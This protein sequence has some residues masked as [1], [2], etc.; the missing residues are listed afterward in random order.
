MATN[1][2]FKQTDFTRTALDNDYEACEFVNCSFSEIR[3]GKIGFENC[4]FVQC[5]FS[6]CRMDTTTWSDVQFIDCKMTGI[7]FS[8]CNPYTLSITFQHSQLQYAIFTALNLQGTTFT[9]C[10]LQEADFSETNLKGAKFVE[11]DLARTVFSS[12]NLE[13]ADLSTSF[14]YIID[15]V[16]NRLRQAK[17]SR[18]GLAGL[19]A[20]FGIVLV[21]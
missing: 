5:N 20:S 13:K 7:D 9:E 18:E 6:L 21:D 12:T 2:S 1:T 3:F 16:A 8:R 19:V 10:N 4:R 15:P 17:F 14:N 11:C